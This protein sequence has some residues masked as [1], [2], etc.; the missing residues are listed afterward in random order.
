[1]HHHH[2]LTHCNTNYKNTRGKVTR[3]H[4]TPRLTSLSGELDGAAP[5]RGELGQGRQRVEGDVAADEV[6]QEDVLGEVMHQERVESP[7]DRV[8]TVEGR[9]VRD[10][11]G[12]AAG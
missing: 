7:V 3:P 6:V 1:M 8:V 9:V 12:V 4:P 10:Q 2:C 11:S 5:Q